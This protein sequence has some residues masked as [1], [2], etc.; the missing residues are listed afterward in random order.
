MAAVPPRVMLHPAPPVTSQLTPAAGAALDL[1]RTLI[2][3]PSVTPADEGCL[4]LIAQ[5]LG[6]NGFVAER[7]DRNGVS[8]LWLRHGTQRPTFVFAGHTDVVPPGPAGTWSTDP[9]TPVEREGYLYGRGAADMKS[10][11]AAF[12]TAAQ[13]YVARHPGH[14]GSIAL[15]L[16]S[17]EEGPALDGTVAVVEALGRRGE[18]IDYCL[19]GEPTCVERLGDTIKNGRRGSL[20][21]R[22]VV[23][24]IQGHVAYPQLARNPIHELAPVLDALVNVQWD[25]GNASFPPTS[26]QV[27]NIRGGT[28]AG[29]VIPGHCEIEFNL[30]FS[31]ESTPESLTRLAELSGRKKSNLSRTLKTMERYG[32]VL[33]RRGARG[34]V[35]PR[36]PYSRISLTLQLS[37]PGRQGKE[38]A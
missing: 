31:P 13:E 19:V 10:S 30:R 8:N 36:V 23:K 28:G 11:I 3:R 24:G 18:A 1:A 5:R 32:F 25:E 12:A 34:S 6:A 15:L 7:F 2:A 26:F 21:G 16:T 29:N 4:D 38:A 33:L 9:F 20:S 14:P 35:I 22:L 17:D 37:T 27:S